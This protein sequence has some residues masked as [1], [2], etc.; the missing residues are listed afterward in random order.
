M[1][2]GCDQIQATSAS[3]MQISRV[4]FSFEVYNAEIRSKP[5]GGR[6]N[7]H[8]SSYGGMRGR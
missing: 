8:C 3:F 7:E 5:T 1:N 2:S 6:H 4:M